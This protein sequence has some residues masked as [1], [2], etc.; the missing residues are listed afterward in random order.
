M[1]FLDKYKK[2]FEEYDKMEKDFIDDDLIWEKIKAHENTTKEE[3]R[4]VLKK[5]EQCIRLEPD[6]MAILCGFGERFFLFVKM[7]EFTHSPH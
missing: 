5:A 6:E 7:A 2:D 1:N 3:V 4:K